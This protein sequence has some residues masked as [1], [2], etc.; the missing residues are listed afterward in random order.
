MSQHDQVYAAVSRPLHA[1][2]RSGDVSSLK[3]A[4]SELERSYS[5]SIAYKDEWI[6]NKQVHFSAATFKGVEQALDSVLKD[7]G[8]YYEKAGDNFYV[9]YKKQMRSANQPQS[10]TLMVPS[11]ALDK[12][13]DFSTF[14]TAEPIQRVDVRAAIAA[15]TITGV[16]KDESGVGFPGVNVVEKGT[17]NGTTTDSDGKFSLTVADDNAVLVFSFVGYASQETPVGGRTVIDISLNPDLQSLD[18]VVVTALGIEKSAKSLG[19]ATSKVTGDQISVNRG[20][21]VMSTLQGKVAGVNVTSL[22]TGPGGSSK[23]RIRGQ[24]SF[25]GQ[26]TPLIVVNGVPIDNT[27]F[28]TN[29]GNTAGDNSVANKGGGASTDGGDGLN[30]I[31]PDD[32]ENMTV[33]KGATAAALYGSRAKDGVIMI[34]TKSRTIGARGI[35]VTYNMNYTDEKILDFTDYQYEYGQGENGLGPASA[36]ALPNPTTGQW[37]FGPKIEPGMTQLLYNNVQVP[38]VAQ[39]GIL[40][41]F[42]RHGQNFTNSVSLSANSDKGGMNLSVSNMDSKGVTP[43]NSYKRNTLNLGFS[44]DLSSKFSF[45]GNVNYANEVTKNPPVVSDQDNSIP[46]SLY[47]MANT[48][49]LELLRAN[50]YNPGG[51]EYLYS[52]FTNR[53]NPYWVLDQVK[54]NIRRDRIMGNLSVKYDFTKWLSLQVRGGQDFWT[55]D[56]DYINLPTGKASISSGSVLAAVPG[57]F[58]GLY[59]QEARRFRETNIDFLLT[60]NKE[61]GNFGLNVTGGGNQMRRRFDSNVVQVTDFVV[62]DLYTV[63]NGRAK[64][65]TY[66]L[67]ERGVNSLYGTAEVNYKQFLYLNATVR[68]DWF[69]TLSPGNRSILYP[70]VSA[71]YVFTQTLGDNLSWLNFGKVRAAFASVG[72]DSDVPP[73]ANQLFY[74]VN[75]NQFGGQPVGTSA[76]LVPNANLRP[77][78]VDETELGL[79]LK[80][81]DNRVNVDLAV[82]KKITTDQIVRAQVSDASGYINTLINSG[83]SQNKGIELMV[84]LVPVRTDNFQWDFT[85][86]GAYN[87]TKVL[88]II[89][90]TPG[91]NITTGTHVFNGFV[92]QIVGEELGQIVG[93]GYRRDDGSVN[94]DHKGMIVY[95]ANGVALPTTKLIPFGSALPKWVGGFTNAFNY[96]GITAS[97][98][99]DFKLGGKVL[100]GTNFNAYRHGL[101]K[102]TLVGREGGVDPVTGAQKGAVVGVGVNAA[103]EINNVAAVAEDF[104]SVVR[105]SGLI[106]PV[107]YDA[108]YWKLRQIT[109]GYDFTKFLSASF[110]IKGL[111]LSFVANNVLMLKKWV[112]NI[113]PESFSYGSDNVVGLESPSVPTTR[114]I[115]F[116][117]NVKF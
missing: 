51:G 76:T 13:E 85:F 34:T 17:T 61:F 89:T 117:L 114:S 84:N 9:I 79:E 21:N 58:N 67:V 29:Q 50:A 115:G 56:S 49:P 96:K 82:Y 44:Y 116:N 47:A 40:N 75:A 5:I 3:Q 71:S 19:Y 23:I 108:G 102:E 66:D 78:K 15:K 105:G 97:V 43:N 94:P 46:T 28:G 60:F 111:R 80:M 8:L 27:S 4:L 98:L 90:D 39:K 69:S 64:D 104:Y 41:K 11:L 24:S 83:K 91:E 68:N 2:Q 74:S 63:Q 86:N 112:P 113:D 107:I 30:S 55:R 33:L 101:S 72:S 31:N 95:G 25:G 88:S 57:F 109:V 12:A 48:M 6:E 103:S 87:I 14:A 53:T 92:Q 36:G 45:K 38:Y 65:P 22:G 10:S 52:R 35:G 7:T 59:T 93:F 70:S 37:S 81:F 54:G 62:K 73:Y 1:Q 18:E 42:Y 99:I 77:M 32:I 110:P 100:S 16:V 26:N 20:S 106:E